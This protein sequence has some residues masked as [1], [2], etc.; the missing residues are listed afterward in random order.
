MHP[1]LTT[2]QRDSDTPLQVGPAELDGSCVKSA[3]VVTEENGQ[4]SIQAALTDECSTRFA[5]FSD[6]NVGREIAL[7]VDGVV[8]SAPVVRERIDGGMF[9]LSLQVSVPE[10]AAMLKQ[11]SAE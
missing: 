2:P 7:V 8:I 6:Q 1:A 3:L 4:G 9:T 11:L 5:D 10:A